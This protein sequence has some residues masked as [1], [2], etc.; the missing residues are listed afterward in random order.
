MLFD[1]WYLVKCNKILMIKWIRWIWLKFLQI[2]VSNDM[3]KLFVDP[4]K[5]KES[6]IDTMCS[7]EKI[8]GH[9]TARVRHIKLG[10]NLNLEGDIFK[11]YD[12]LEHSPVSTTNEREKVLNTGLLSKNVLIL[13]RASLHICYIFTHFFWFQIFFSIEQIQTKDRC[14]LW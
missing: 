13:Q 2:H 5:R 4:L 6:T 3:L 9:V 11:V 12:R 10:F 8:L 1:T 14:K 7:F